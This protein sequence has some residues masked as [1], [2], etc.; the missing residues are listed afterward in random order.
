MTA[1][2]SLFPGIDSIEGLAGGLHAHPVLHCLHTVVQQGLE[3]QDRLDH[4]LQ[5]EF[6]PAVSGPA[7]PA[8]AGDDVDAQ[9]VRV[10]LRQ[11]RDVIGHPAL[12]RID[13]ALRQQPLQ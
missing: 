12:F 7:V 8:L 2:Q 6:L 11:L 1:V 13:T 10:A 5:G 9:R 3:Q 4:A